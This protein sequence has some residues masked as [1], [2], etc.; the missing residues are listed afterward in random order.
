MGVL[1]C[2]PSCCCHRP[3]TLFA[4]Q[5]GCLWVKKGVCRSRRVSSLVTLMGLKTLPYQPAAVRAQDSLVQSD[6]HMMSQFTTIS[7]E[8]LASADKPFSGHSDALQQAFARVRLHECK[9]PSLL[10]VGT[11]V[12]SYVGAPLHP[13]MA[14]DLCQIFNLRARRFA[15]DHFRHEH[16]LCNHQTCLDRKFIVFMTE[17][18]LKQHAAREHGGDLSKAERRQALTIPINFQVRHDVSASVY[19]KGS[20]MARCA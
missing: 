13:S 20:R 9:R 4:G 1:L 2:T 16:Y 17:Q 7:S 8:A 18:E 6:R 11:W 15:A 19:I 3:L 12:S 10:C 14:L 5:E